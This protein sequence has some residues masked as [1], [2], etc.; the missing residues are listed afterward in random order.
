MASISSKL[1]LGKYPK[2]DF[3][4]EFIDMILE[5]KKLATT[6]YLKNEPDLASLEIGD[7]V[8]ARADEEPGRPMFAL[9]KIEK[10]E[11]MRFENIDLKLAQIE[12]MASA[13]QLKK[14]LRKFYPSI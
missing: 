9:L 1:D 4:S 12:N 10:V 14:V 5:S 7:E 11:R 8:L 13:D 6:R 2:I 3:A